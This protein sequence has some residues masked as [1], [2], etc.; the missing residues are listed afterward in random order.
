[1]PYRTVYMS[2]RLDTYDTWLHDYIICDNKTHS[3]WHMT[4]YNTCQINGRNCDALSSSFY[5]FIYLFIFHQQRYFITRLLKSRLLVGWKEVDVIHSLSL[6][7]LITWSIT[8]RFTFGIMST[9]AWPKSRVT[10]SRSW[11][12]T[13]LWSRDHLIVSASTFRLDFN[14]SY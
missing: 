1:M 12:F 6:F 9:S 13:W 11:N 8:W 10:R 2:V 14:V 4:A 7:P 3:T 5:L